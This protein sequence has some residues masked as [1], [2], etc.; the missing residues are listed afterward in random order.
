MNVRFWECRTY[1]RMAE[2]GRA[3]ARQLGADS[4]LSAVG[5]EFRIAAVRTV[6]T[7]EVNLRHL[8]S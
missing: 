4:G 5:N 7:V 6:T 1:C 2:I 8:R 3:A